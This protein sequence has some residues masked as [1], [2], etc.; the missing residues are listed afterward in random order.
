MR[1]NLLIEIRSRM[2]KVF[3]FGGTTE[4]RVMAEKLTGQGN[5]VTVSV[6]TE[7]GAEELAGIPCQVH[8]GRMDAS[9][10]KESIRGFDLVI[11]ATH[12]YAALASRNIREACSSAGVPLQRIRRDESDFGDSIRVGSCTEAAGFLRDTTGRI[13]ITTGSKEL[14]VFAILDPNRL[15]PRVLPTHEALSICE[16]MKIP[17]RNIIAMQGPFSTEMNEA[18]LCQFGISYLVTKDGGKEGGFEEKR[19]AARR[20]NVQLI[21]IERPE[22]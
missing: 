3:I 10:M 9:E 11:D 4:G 17:H 22:V 1:K 20:N 16:E 8:V 5:D 7:V 2:M 19:E 12:P 15:Y 13:L 18:I 6:A 21:V 14:H